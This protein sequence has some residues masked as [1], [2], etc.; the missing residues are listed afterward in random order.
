[1][2]VI[3]RISILLLFM[4]WTGL[5]LPTDALSDSVVERSTCTSSCK[6]VR[7]EWGS[8]TKAERTSY[9]NAVLCLQKRPSI[10]P[11]GLVPGAKSRFDDFVA[12]HINQT[13][14]IHLDGIFLAWHREFVWLYEQALRNECG[15]TGTQPYW[16]WA[17]WC[18]SLS[19]SPLFDGSATSLS[20]DGVFEPDQGPYV[21][22]EGETLP[23]GTG[24]GCAL[25][26]PFQNMTVN[27]GPFDF[28][29]VF[30]GVLPS[31]W[32]AYNPHC[33][34]R[35]LNNYISTRYGNQTAIDVLMAKTTIADFQN[36]MSG[37]DINLG[38]HGGGHFALGPTLLDF[39]ASP[40][41]P[42][43]YLH[44]GMIDRVWTL[45]QAADPANRVNALS[46]TSTIFN[47]NTT[48]NVTLD[49]VVN[50]GYLGP[51]KTLRQ[52]VSVTAGD[53]CYGYQ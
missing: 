46:G 34:T 20:G 48:P 9:I 12:T 24:G 38:V 14:S 35:D 19:T 37:A 11:K 33:L 44:H 3:S 7:K 21:V 1:M 15:Y 6:V 29:I 5:C 32:T 47:Q 36:T 43:F 45:W 18:N 40:S 2:G 17:L 8:L 31:N 52:L 42:A 30:T 51:P 4:S 23:H 25:S 16:N 49:T 10:I 53:F 41:D 26:G 13:L 28:S 27:M 39:F 22:G 50:W